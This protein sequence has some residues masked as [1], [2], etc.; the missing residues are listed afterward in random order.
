ML[1]KHEE[2]AERQRRGRK[3]RGKVRCTLEVEGAAYEECR[4]AGVLEAPNLA[5]GPILLHIKPTLQNGA[6]AKPTLQNGAQS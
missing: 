3:R 4:K 2:G 1:E 6:Q 5:A